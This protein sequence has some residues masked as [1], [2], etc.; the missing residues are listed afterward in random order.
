MF[1]ICMSVSENHFK[2]Q[3]VTNFKNIPKG[4]YNKHSYTM[5]WN[6]IINVKNYNENYIKN[7]VSLKIIIN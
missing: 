3:F 5:P 2:N 1:E 4:F 7:S 6:I